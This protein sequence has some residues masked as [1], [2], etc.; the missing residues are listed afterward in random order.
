M[1]AV[2]S[3]ENAVYDVYESPL[4]DGWRTPFSCDLDNGE[5]VHIYS[6]VIAFWVNRKDKNII[7]FCQILQLLETFVSKWCIRIV[8]IYDFNQMSVI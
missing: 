2:W 5:N 8:D 7:L 1:F 6:D 3:N 4:S